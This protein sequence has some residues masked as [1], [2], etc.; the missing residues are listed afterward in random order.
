MSYP[1]SKADSLDLPAD[2]LFFASRGAK[3]L[4]NDLSRENADKVVAEVKAAG[5][6]DAIAN[7]DSATE[8]DKIVKQVVDKWGRV[9]VSP[10]SLLWVC[11]ARATGEN[12]RVQP[13][14][15]ACAARLAA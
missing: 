12:P 6:G 1:G 3:V 10:R 2:T 5:K 11:L 9:D 13:R 14:A 8:G 15:L 4:V 7:Y